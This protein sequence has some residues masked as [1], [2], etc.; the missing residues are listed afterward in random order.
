MLEFNVEVRPPCSEILKE[1][2]LTDTDQMQT[3]ARYPHPI[4]RIYTPELR[5]NFLEISCQC[6]LLLV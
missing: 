5:R 2:K 6:P 1:S 4:I 3:V